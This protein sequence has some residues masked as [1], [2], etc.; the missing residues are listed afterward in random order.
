MTTALSDAKLQ[1][2]LALAA[3]VLLLVLFFVSG[4]RKIVEFPVF[5]S[6]IASKGLPFPGAGAV[7]AA[8]LEIGATVLLVAGWKT[9]PTALILAVYTLIAGVL[10]HDFWNMQTAGLQGAQASNQMNHFL[11]NLSICGG[12]LLLAALGPGAWSVDMRSKKEAEP[13]A[14]PRGT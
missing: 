1:A 8:I 13:H 6:F 5:V 11:K 4:I 7:L 10:F 3:R 14:S 2:Q 12:L 9:R